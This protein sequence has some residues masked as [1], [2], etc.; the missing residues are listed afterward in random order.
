MAKIKINL[1]NNLSKK[2]QDKTNWIK[3]YNQSQS[4]ADRVASQDAENPVLKN[5]RFKRI[6]D[7]S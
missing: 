2:A 7:K 6:N 3:I 4:T 1:K 5:T